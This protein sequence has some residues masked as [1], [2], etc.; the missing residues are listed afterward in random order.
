MRL[1][2]LGTAFT[3]QH[4][5]SRILEQLVY[6]WAHSRICI[7]KCLEEQYTKL[8]R[9]FDERGGGDATERCEGR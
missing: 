3:A 1:E 4:S 7:S 6:K 8:R 2:L 5:D 9:T